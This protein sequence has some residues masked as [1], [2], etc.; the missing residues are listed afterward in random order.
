MGDTDPDQKAQT[1]DGNPETDIPIET[2]VSV[3]DDATDHRDEDK[4]DNE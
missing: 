3:P 4:G 1:Q 2:V